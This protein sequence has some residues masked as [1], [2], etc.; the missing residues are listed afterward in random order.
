MLSLLFDTV[1]F[2]LEIIGQPAYSFSA[3]KKHGYHNMLCPLTL[4]IFLGNSSQYAESTEIL[5]QK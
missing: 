4:G 3:E 5:S 2:K 1:L